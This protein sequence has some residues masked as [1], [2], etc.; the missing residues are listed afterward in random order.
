[1]K[2]KSILLIAMLTIISF[3]CNHI[4]Q[5]LNEATKDTMKMAEPAKDSSMNMYADN[6]VDN[7]KDPSC[8][9]PVTAGVGDTLHYN[10]KVLGFCSKECKDD[11]L[12]DA[13][14]NFASVEWKK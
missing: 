11:F 3:S 6:L 14:K 5:H 10:N 13:K 1:M 12:K 4:Q 9:M 8:G 2:M 7:K